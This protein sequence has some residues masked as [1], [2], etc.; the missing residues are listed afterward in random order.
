MLSKLQR[1][2]SILHSLYV[3]R[4]L[5]WVWVWN[6][7]THTRNKSVIF[8][9]FSFYFHTLKSFLGWSSPRFCFGPFSLFS[10]NMRNSDFL[11]E[12][13][14]INWLLFHDIWPSGISFCSLYFMLCKHA[15]TGFYMDCF[16]GILLWTFR[17][18][19]FIF[20][21]NSYSYS[22]NCGIWYNSTFSTAVC[23]WV[24]WQSFPNWHRRRH[25]CG[26]DF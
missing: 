14:L 5:F 13:N 18:R 22:C 6:M 26:V 4:F 17:D 16:G 23:C 11:F 8:Q 21:S 1:Y 3:V 7:I 19:I 2:A 12:K 10:R 25:A 15:I 24:G 9:V 20:F